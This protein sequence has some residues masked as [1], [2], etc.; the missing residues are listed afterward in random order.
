MQNDTAISF[1]NLPDLSQEE[2]REIFLR[3]AGWTLRYL[4]EKVGVTVSTLSR[5]LRNPTMPTAQH[6][7][8][9][10]LGMPT[11]LLPEPQDIRRGPKSRLRPDI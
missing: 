6:Q 7:T 5:S 8:L 3:R 4:A 9:V 10:K 11:E 2:K 1:L